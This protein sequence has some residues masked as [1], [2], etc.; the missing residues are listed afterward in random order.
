MNL[1]EPLFKFFVLGW[2][3]S[4]TSL[5]HFWVEVVKINSLFSFFFNFGQYSYSSSFYYP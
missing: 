1:I 2:V 4:H 3:K 5:R